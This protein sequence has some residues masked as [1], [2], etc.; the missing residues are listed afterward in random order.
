MSRFDSPPIMHDLF[1]C[2]PPTLV[3]E[4]Q[5][6]PTTAKAPVPE[7]S[8]LSDAGLAQLLVDLT[9]EVQRRRSGKAGQSA[10]PALDRAIQEVLRTLETCLRKP[11]RRA[12]RVPRAASASSVQEA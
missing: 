8:S 5:R 10:R 9:A 7:L 11:D 1:D 3:Q 2:V 12:K 6:T 4:V